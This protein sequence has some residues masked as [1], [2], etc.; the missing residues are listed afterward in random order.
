MRGRHYRLSQI[1]HGASGPG[2]TLCQ[3]EI[4]F[5]F[6]G[7]DGAVAAETDAAAFEVKSAVELN[8]S[9]DREIAIDGDF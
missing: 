3:I 7:V 1:D 4:D 8:G 6:G 5:I 9:S 2:G